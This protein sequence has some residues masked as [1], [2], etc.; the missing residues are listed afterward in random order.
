LER[1]SAE[2]ETAIFRLVQEAL[3]NVH[4]H[5][6]STSATIRLIRDAE[7]VAVEVQDRGRGMPATVTNSNSTI[8]VGIQ[9]MRE[10]VRQLGGRFEI[11]SGEQGTTLL[12]VL[13][14]SRSLLQS[15]PNIKRPG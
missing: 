11:K 13:P 2:T 7:T 6:S 12:A 5:S 4:R 10:R 9:G 15:E 8:G 14:N 1:M 3:T